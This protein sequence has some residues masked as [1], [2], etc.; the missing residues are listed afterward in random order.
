MYLIR[1]I[2]EPVSPFLFLNPSKSCHT[3]I[4]NLISRTVP[5][6][7]F[8]FPFDSLSPP[9]LPLLSIPDTMRDIGRTS[10]FDSRNPRLQEFLDEA[11]EE[12]VSEVGV[13][14][15]FLV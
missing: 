10:D 8:F 12:E 14:C 15:S 13:V 1:H 7:S 2:T 9:L 3:S 11:V 6:I 4:S 5:C